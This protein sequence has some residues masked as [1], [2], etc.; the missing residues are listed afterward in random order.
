MEGNLLSN[1]RSYS[2]VLKNAGGKI[3]V[4]R[5]KHWIFMS[6]EKHCKQCCVTCEYFQQCIEDGSQG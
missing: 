5:L 2:Y 6:K 4:K 1:F 3:V